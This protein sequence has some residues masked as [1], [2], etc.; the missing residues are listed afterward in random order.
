MHQ[1]ASLPV[2]FTLNDTQ[3]F[4]E[5]RICLKIAGSGHQYIQ[6]PYFLTGIRNSLF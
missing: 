4:A 1:Y 5:K 3:Q 6:I 2:D